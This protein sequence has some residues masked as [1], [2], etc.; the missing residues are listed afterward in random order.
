MMVLNEEL[1]K[2]NKLAKSG[3]NGHCMAGRM[4]SKL[5]HK[6]SCKQIC[7]QANDS[8]QAL[9]SQLSIEALLVSPVGGFSI[10]YSV[11]FSDLVILPHW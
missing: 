8:C 2:K 11:V 3:N 5:S 10:V 1:K 7:L 9:L 6:N 4:W